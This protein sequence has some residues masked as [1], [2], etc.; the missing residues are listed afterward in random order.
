MLNFISD[1]GDAIKNHNE[2]LLHTT[3]LLKTSK[4]LAMSTVGKD[5]NSH[6]LLVKIINYGYYGEKVL[7]LYSKPENAYNI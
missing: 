2:I 5:G 6:S 1:Q 4:N 3:K 7:A